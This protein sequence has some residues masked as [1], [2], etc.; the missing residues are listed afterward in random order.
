MTTIDRAR[1]VISGVG[2]QGVLFITRLMA[3][4][5]IRKGFPVMTSETHGMAQ[6]GGSVISHLKVG[7]FSS[8]LIR[9]GAADGLI[10]LK[11][12]SLERHG[13]FLKPEAWA[14]INA[15][16]DPTPSPGVDT[17]RIDADGLARRIGNPRAVNLIVLG[18]ALGGARTEVAAL[19]GIDDITAV[20]ADRLSDT[21]SLLKASCS[22]LEAGVAAARALAD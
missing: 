9:V 1:L 15:D 8:P 3:E 19:W 10:G 18:F 5:V 4:A 12:E 7:V 13:H 14:C 6:R 16:T 22:A 2:G 21:P 17:R 20:L 11:T